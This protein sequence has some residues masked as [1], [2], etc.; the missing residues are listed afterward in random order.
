MRRS[1]ILFLV[2]LASVWLG[3][4]LNEEPGYLLLAYKHWVIEMPLWFCIV[5]LFV[6]F[7]LFYLFLRIVHFFG[8]SGSRIKNWLHDREK[9]KALTLTTQGLIEFTEGQWAVAEKHLVKAA[10]N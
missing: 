1:I 6:L 7:I 4:R 2:L 8:L 5:L 3:L 9:Q 10:N